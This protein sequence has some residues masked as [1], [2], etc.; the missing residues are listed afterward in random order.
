MVQVKQESDD[1]DVPDKVMIEHI[2]NG[3]VI[4]TYCHSD[5][6]KV[7]FGKMLRIKGKSIKDIERMTKSERTEEKD[8]DKTTVK[9]KITK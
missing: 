1:D 3:F 6:Q 4:T 9:I 8:G 2:D 5:E 7:Y